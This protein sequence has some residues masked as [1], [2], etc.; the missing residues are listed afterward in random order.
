MTI[1]IKDLRSSGQ[2][3]EIHSLTKHDGGSDDSDVPVLVL[4]GRTF[5]NDHLIEIRIPFSELEDLQSLADLIDGDAEIEP[6]EH[7]RSAETGQF[8]TEEAAEEN[9]ETT[10]KE[11]S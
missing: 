8:V 7:F 10:V 4:H 5:L 6:V 11:T 9:P 1:K 2:I 3:G